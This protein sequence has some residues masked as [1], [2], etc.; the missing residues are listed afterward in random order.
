M[1]HTG[2]SL[3][4]LFVGL[5]CAVGNLHA[6]QSKSAANTNVVGRVAHRAAAQQSQGP[7]PQIAPSQV[8]VA[9]IGAVHKPGIYI[10]HKAMRPLVNCCRVPAGPLPKATSRSGSMSM[11]RLRGSTRLSVWR[12]F[13]CKMGR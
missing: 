12:L 3:F 5:L 6:Q 8:T 4:V 11:L 10:S 7:A 9:L 1:R 13:H 2:Q